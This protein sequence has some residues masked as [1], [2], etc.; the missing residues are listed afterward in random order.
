MVFEKRLTSWDQQT[1]PVHPK[2]TFAGRIRDDEAPE[3][4]VTRWWKHWCDKEG[5]MRLSEYQLGCYRGKVDRYSGCAWCGE[6]P[7]DI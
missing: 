6:L 7:P 1:F 3:G 4:E 5:L 2:W